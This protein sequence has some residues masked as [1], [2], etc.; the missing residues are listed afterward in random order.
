MLRVIIKSLGNGTMPKL[1]QH[2]ST[3][4]NVFGRRYYGEING[5]LALKGGKRAP[6]LPHES[7]ANYHEF[8]FLSFLAGFPVSFLL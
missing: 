6:N 7:A 3:H 4:S 1:L 8:F 2:I 5:M